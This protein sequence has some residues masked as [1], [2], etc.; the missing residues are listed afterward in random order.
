[1]VQPARDGSISAI[2]LA[3]TVRCIRLVWYWLQILFLCTDLLIKNI[4]KKSSWLCLVRSS[5]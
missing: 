5:Q 3:H 4:R 2:V 1:M